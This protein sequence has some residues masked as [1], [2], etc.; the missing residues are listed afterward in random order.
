MSSDLPTPAALRP[1]R[2]NTAAPDRRLTRLR[3][4]ILAGIVALAVGIRS[5]GIG[6][7]S[8]WTDEFVSLEASTGRGFAHERLPVNR[9]LDPAE[10]YTSL[11]GAPGWWQIWT[12]SAADPHPPLF[13]LLLRPWRAV[14]GEGDAAARAFSLFASLAAVIALFDAVRHTSGAAPALWAALLMTLAGPQIE[15]SQEARSYLLA[16]AFVCACSA[17]AARIGW[18]GVTWPRLAALSAAMLAAMLTHYLAAGAMIAVVVFLILRLEARHRLKVVAAVL[19]AAALW[20]ALWGPWIL[21]QRRVMAHVA[22]TASRRAAGAEAGA[23]RSLDRVVALPV[24]QFLEPGPDTAWVGRF[25]AVLLV[26]PLMMWRRRD[27]I[28]WWLIAIGSVATVWTLDIWNGTAFLDSIRYTLLASGAFCAIP[29]TLLADRKGWL[30]ALVPATL[31]LGCVLSLDRSVAWQQLKPPWRAF[32]QEQ[33]ARMSP[34]DRIVV[35]QAPGDRWYAGVMYLALT[36]YAAPLPCPVVVLRQPPPASLRQELAQ[37]R[38]VWVLAEPAGCPLE[39]L[40]GPVNVLS[41]SSE[42]QIGH[43]LQVRVVPRREEGAD[44]PLPHGSVLPTT[45]P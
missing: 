32:V 15:F 39:Q 13:Q 37:A 5:W 35:Y 12:D 6:R 23:L 26:L 40:L 27:L 8:L 44:G 24:R 11:R 3:L 42:P 41:S 33:A 31:A 2:P 20:A 28:F 29:A 9:W 22:D 30:T 25:G 36:H 16:V 14:F 34:D 18:A 43:W 17:A 38:T 45:S 21:E 1:L 4:L 7:D 10:D 19:A